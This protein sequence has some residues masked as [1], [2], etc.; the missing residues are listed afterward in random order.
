MR[1]AARTLGI[2]CR[3]IGAVSLL[4]TLA[5][6]M[7]VSWMGWCHERL[8]LGP[9]PEGPVVEYLA[10][11]VSA[12]YALFGAM[13]WIVGGDVRRY[14]PTIACLAWFMIVFGVV[15]TGVDVSLDLPVWWTVLEGPPLVALGGAMLVLQARVR[16]EAS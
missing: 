15:I 1:T 3:M 4:A 9:L 12:F 10:R 16:R 13:L 2:L 5:V 14:G 11:S 6:F 7:P 8:G